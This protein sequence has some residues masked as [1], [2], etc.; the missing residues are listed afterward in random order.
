VAKQLQFPRLTRRDCERLL[1]V[2]QQLNRVRDVLEKTS[3]TGGRVC[4]GGIMTALVLISELYNRA[5]QAFLRN[6]DPPGAPPFEEGQLVE[7]EVTGI[8]VDQAA[9]AETTP[10]E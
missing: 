8:P 7:T 1:D 2:H 3:W 5:E 6:S 4:A 10:K 9:P